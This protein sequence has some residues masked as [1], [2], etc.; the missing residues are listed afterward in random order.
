MKLILIRGINDF[1]TG[2]QFL[3]KK[4][5]KL[6]GNNIEFNIPNDIFKGTNNCLPCEIELFNEK[7]QSKK[8][9][10]HV[11]ICK[12]IFYVYLTKFGFTY[13]FIFL[14]EPDFKDLRNSDIGYEYDD[15][16]NKHRI[17]ISLINCNENIIEINGFCLPLRAL[18]QDCHNNNN[19]NNSYQFSIYS[20]D[21]IICKISELYELKINFKEFYDKY[22]LTIRESYNSL[23]NSIQ[24][25]A[26]LDI[27]KSLAIKQKQIIYEFN[28]LNFHISKLELEQSLN[29]QSYFEFCYYLLVHKFLTRSLNQINNTSDLNN[30]IDN[31]KKFKDLIES[32]PDLKIYQKI[33]GLIQYN[34]ISIFH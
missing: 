23:I 22:N 11:Y 1:F 17:R 6:T 3:D 24:K 14:D 18:C 8:Y 2:I 16:D 13:E 4:I 12:N 15:N 5:T 20:K 33:F 25:G 34:Y 21:K 26:D 31:F 7:K 9:V 28:E 27:L 32:D 10:V 30:A 29:D 19:K